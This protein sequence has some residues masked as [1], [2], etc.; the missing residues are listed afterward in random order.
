MFVTLF[1]GALNTKTGVLTFINA[2]H[3]A[4]SVLHAAGSIESVGDKPAMPLG[5]RIGA[6]Y[7]EQIV[8][9]LPEDTVFVF[10]DG[11]TEAMNVADEFYG[12]ERLQADLRAASALTPGEI[13]R[14]IKGKVDVFT[15]Q[16]PKFDDVTMLALR[17]Q[18]CVAA[19]ENQPSLAGYNTL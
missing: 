13:V 18:P 11:V 5:V 3:L 9:L 14:T 7:Q 15:G 12:N 10:S 4:P 2:G 8:T 16:A 1:L 19:M 6:A 17:W